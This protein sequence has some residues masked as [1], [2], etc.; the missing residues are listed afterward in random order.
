MLWK[1]QFIIITNNQIVER[2]KRSE[3]LYKYVNEEAGNFTFLPTGG[4]MIWT[5]HWT[6][7]F[8]L[9]KNVWY[10]TLEVYLCFHI[11][12][13]MSTYLGTF[14]F[15]LLK[16][17]WYLMHY[18]IFLRVTAEYITHVLQNSLLPLISGYMLYLVSR[19][20]SFPVIGGRHMILIYQRI[21]YFCCTV[22]RL[23]SGYVR[24]V[25]LDINMFI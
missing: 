14:Y 18:R 12:G 2:T 20:I 24:S 23:V 13:R 19:N 16:N 7:C 22:R 6:L 9:S 11:W 1:L 4:N 3:Q 17:I 10:L 21:L 25:V 5:Y 15:L 8:L